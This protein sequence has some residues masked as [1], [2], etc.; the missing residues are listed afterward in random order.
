MEI[1]RESVSVMRDFLRRFPQICLCNGDDFFWQHNSVSVIGNSFPS[2]KYLS[3]TNLDTMV[4]RKEEPPSKKE[5]SPSSR[6]TV[7]E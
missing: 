1:K 6:A 4:K 7:N 5:D 2:E 3:V